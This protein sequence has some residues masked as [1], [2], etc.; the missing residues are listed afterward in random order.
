MPSEDEVIIICKRTS[1]PGKPIP[2]SVR[3]H[4]E[5]C[6]VEV[7][8]AP[9][10]FEEYPQGRI[11]CLA[12]YGSILQADPEAHIPFLTSRQMTELARSTKARLN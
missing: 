7:W 1:S 6:E 10:S 8:V 4:C 3:R 2:G 12:C 5:K 11:L 9:S